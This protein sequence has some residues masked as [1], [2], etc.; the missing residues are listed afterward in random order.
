M[1]CRYSTHLSAGSRVKRFWS[2]DQPNCVPDP[3]TER[4]LSPLPPLQSKQIH[5]PIP[6]HPI[7]ST[8][9]NAAKILHDAL[10]LTEGRDKVVKLLQY[11]S[12]LIVLLPSTPSKRLRPFISQMSMTRKVIKLGHGIFPYVELTKGG[13]QTFALVRAIV[14]ILN[15]FWD[16]VY[17]LS[18]IGFLRS[19]K[20]QRWSENWA[21]RAWMMGIIMDLYVLKQ[22]RDVTKM[23]LETIPEKKFLDV[24]GPS[25]E[26]DR[27]KARE[28]L[29]IEAY[30]IDISIVKLLADLGFCCSSSSNCFTDSSD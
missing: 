7:P 5:P 12:R 28:K 29:S 20:L 27:V 8:S 17:C 13:L 6:L 16:D 23:K 10:L 11:T 26:E 24:K 3:M 25:L 9:V 18:R 21:N 14:E 19:P 4:S 15:D 2:D 22:K 1:V 30:W